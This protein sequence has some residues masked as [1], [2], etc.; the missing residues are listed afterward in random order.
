AAVQGKQDCSFSAGKRS[1]QPERSGAPEFFPRGPG[2]VRAT[3]RL[4]RQRVARSAVRAAEGQAAPATDPA[5]RGEDLVALT[6]PLA[7]ALQACPA[8]RGALYL[9]LTN[10]AEPEERW[11]YQVH[12]PEHAGLL[13]TAARPHQ[14]DG[15]VLLVGGRPGLAVF[16]EMGEGK[17]KQGIDDLC[18]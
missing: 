18:W 6:L 12:C 15:L 4:L 5:A 13:R 8:C 17:R 7:S 3:A 14:L 9:E 1:L 16:D 10:P 11:T 2:A